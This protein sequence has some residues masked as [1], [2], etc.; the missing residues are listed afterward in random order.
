[1]RIRRLAGL[2]CVVLVVGVLLLPAAS[3]AAEGNYDYDTLFSQ[4]STADGAQAESL[5]RTLGAE[6]RFDP[7]AFIRA[8]TEAP[9][10]E[11]ERVARLL[12]YDAN[13]ADLD[14]YRLMLAEM[15]DGANPGQREYCVLS[16][17]LEACVLLQENRVRAY[18]PSE[19]VHDA[20]VYAFDPDTLLGLIASRRAAG[21]MHDIDEEFAFVLGNA[22]ASDPELFARTVSHLPSDELTA[23]QTFVAYDIVA[24]AKAASE[25]RGRWHLSGRDAAVLSA[26]EADIATMRAEGPRIFRTTGEVGVASTQVPTI[27]PM[28][29]TTTPLHVGQTET[30]KVQFTETTR[31]DILRTYWV[32]VYAVKDGTPWLK[33]STSVSIPAG[34]SSVYAYFTM[35]FSSTGPIYTLVKVYSQQGGTLL[36][37]RQGTYP[38]T[39]YGD[40]KITVSL[41]VNRDYKGT[42][43][44]YR[45]DASL[46]T[47]FECLGRSESN[48]SMY[49]V[50]GN[51]PTGTYTGYL[52]GPSSPSSSYGP[53]KVVNMTGVSGVIVESGRSGIWIHGGDPET[54][55]NLTWYPLRPTYGC[56]RIS[57]T[58]QSSLQTKITSLINSYYHDQVGNI[59]ISES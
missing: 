41:P 24:N 37:Q 20:A 26:I 48:D 12:A 21:L 50:Y 6:F 27:G 30:L 15:R 31:T 42:L 58:N 2:L 1:M 52:D 45:A 55:Q 43:R 54:N 44:L 7:E 53:Y 32:E 33:S 5:A 29:Y 11:V 25:A 59:I 36:T 19:R 17:L 40:W 14:A 56:V 8:L 28:T 57:N 9:P 35:T 18:G 4:T 23:I 49:V 3:A 39:V 38:D 46:F 34:S 16:S 51:T 22:Y 10:Q 47:S 13:Y